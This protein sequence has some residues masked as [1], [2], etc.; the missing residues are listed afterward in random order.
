[1]PG[2]SQR[3]DIAFSLMHISPM[4]AHNVLFCSL[5]KYF[6]SYLLFAITYRV[7]SVQYSYNIDGKKH[8]VVWIGRFVLRQSVYCKYISLL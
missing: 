2:I 3:V 6:S 4:I 8:R 5:Q 7:F 1:M